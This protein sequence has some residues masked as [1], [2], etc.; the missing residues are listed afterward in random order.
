[1]HKH[2]ITSKSSKRLTYSHPSQLLHTA[3]RASPSDIFDSFECQQKP[4]QLELQ[5]L[6]QK[7]SLDL[8]NKTLTHA[9][10]LLDVNMFI[11]AS[12]ST[13]TGKKSRKKTDTRLRKKSISPKSRVGV[14]AASKG[15]Q[16]NSKNQITSKSLDKECV[17][18]QTN[19][20]QPNSDKDES[21]A[22]N[23][24]RGVI[25]AGGGSGSGGGVPVDGQPMEEV[26]VEEPPPPIDPMP[27]TLGQTTEIPIALKEQLR[28]MERIVSQNV[29]HKQ[30]MLYRNYPTIEEL[31]A[32][33][34]AG[35]EDSDTM[36][37]PHSKTHTHT[38]NNNTPGSN[39]N[40]GDTHTERVGTVV[41][42]ERPG[43]TTHT[44]TR[45][46]GGRSDTHTHTHTQGTQLYDD[47]MK[48]IDN[49]KPR[50]HDLFNFECFN[51]TGSRVE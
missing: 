17:S 40:T 51:L 26:R 9:G 16:T 13:P 33:M 47:K 7:E 28:I 38:L 2:S 30:H 10:T 45:D 49:D 34:A 29:Y 5:D 32:I 25:S 23:D 43:E 50:L 18:G 3:R 48:D 41:D 27:W 46:E 39:N 44:H 24:D 35:A 14:K 19:V 20:S 22:V 11:N 37:V 15:N 31:R 12:L 8:M 1:M 6:C 4:R 42:S 21:V 36:P